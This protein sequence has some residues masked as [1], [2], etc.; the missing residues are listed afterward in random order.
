MPTPSIHTA[1]TIKP[2]IGRIPMRAVLIERIRVWLTAR[3]A[4]SA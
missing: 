3:F 1:I 2:T 4:C